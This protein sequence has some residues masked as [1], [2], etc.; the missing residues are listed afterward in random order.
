MLDSAV[1][2][3]AMEALTIHSYGVEVEE[4]AIRLVDDFAGIS[5][6]ILREK[7]IP[8]VAAQAC[9]RWTSR[10][11]RP[12]VAFPDFF[13][14]KVHSVDEHASHVSESGTCQDIKD[15]KCC[16]EHLPLWRV[17]DCVLLHQGRSDPPGCMLYCLF[18]VIHRIT[19][20]K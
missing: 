4:L 6:Y 15:R 11:D 16:E 2:E 18:P 20:F 5:F 7:V 14:A 17:C 19:V 1:A 9:G 8:A 12:A 10:A 13:F 3:S